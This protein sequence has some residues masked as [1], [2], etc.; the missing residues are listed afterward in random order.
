MGGSWRER[1]GGA[2]G[3]GGSKKVA[4][5]WHGAGFYVIAAGL[6]SPGDRGV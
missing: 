2:A 6:L 3:N 5:G 1:H 4:S